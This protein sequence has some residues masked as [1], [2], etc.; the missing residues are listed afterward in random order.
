M[1]KNEALAT[2]DTIKKI[3]DSDGVWLTLTH[4]LKPDL[5]MIKMEISIKVEKE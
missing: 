3:C 1:T 4:D 2:Q 5:K